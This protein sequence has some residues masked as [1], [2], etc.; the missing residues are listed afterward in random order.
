MSTIIHRLNEIGVHTKIH[1]GNILLYPEG[2]TP[3]E[4]LEQVRRHKTT[5]V[6]ELQKSREKKLSFGVQW[7]LEYKADLFKHGWTLQE[8]FV[9]SRTRR[10]ATPG[11]CMLG[12]WDR[13][14]AGNV[15]ASI[16]QE[17]IVFTW[18]ERNGQA[19]RQVSR[20][21]SRSPAYL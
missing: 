20:P 18:I 16:E 21:E 17:G 8:L 6:Q 3:R 5:I 10:I 9:H 13:V 1:N 15:N 2:R 4:L 12:I 7:C 14:K 19:V 11:V